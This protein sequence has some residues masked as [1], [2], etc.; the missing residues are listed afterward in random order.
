[1]DTHSLGITSHLESLGWWH[2][3][4]VGTNWWIRWCLLRRI[5]IISA[6]NEPRLKLLGFGTEGEEKGAATWP[7]GTAHCSCILV[8]SLCL[9]WTAL[10]VSFMNFKVLKHLATGIAHLVVIVIEF[11]MSVPV[12]VTHNIGNCFTQL[13]RWLEMR[14]LDLTCTLKLVWSL[15]L[16]FDKVWFVEAGPLLIRWL[17]PFFH[18]ELLS[19]THVVPSMFAESGSKTDVLGEEVVAIFGLSSCS[20]G[21]RVIESWGQHL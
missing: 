15:S 3:F 18:W 1:M 10:Y 9:S 5:L 2:D 12:W 21:Q 6:W 7:V 4:L 20:I 16:F 17:V 19:D 14:K 13:N 11:L 8:I